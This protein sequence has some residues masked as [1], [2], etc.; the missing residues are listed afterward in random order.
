VD[1]LKG[2]HAL[3]S[4]GLQEVLR[5]VQVEVA[6]CG[7]G[8]ELGGAAIHLEGTDLRVIGLRVDAVVDYG[9]LSVILVLLEHEPRGAVIPLTLLEIRSDQVLIPDAH[10]L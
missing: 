6:H 4:V 3:R 7:V 1:D 9:E 10:H 8:G 5:G 2:S